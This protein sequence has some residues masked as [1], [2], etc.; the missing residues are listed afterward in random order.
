MPSQK[1]VGIA[2]QLRTLVKGPA[3]FIGLDVGSHSVKAVWLSAGEKTCKLRGW[4]HKI[5]DVKPDAAPE[6]KKYAAIAAVKD[7]FSAAGLEKKEVALSVSGNSVIVR[8]VSFPR[9]S[10]AEMENVLATEAEP[11]IP[12]DIKEVNLA[13]HILRDVL[14][15]GQK[16]METI[17]VAAK[18][19]LIREK[20]EVITGAGLTPL[21]VDV[22]IFALEQ[23]HERLGPSKPGPATLFLNIG[24]KTTNIAIIENGVTRVA[25]DVFIAG[26]MLTKAIAKTI[27]V[28]IPKAEELKRKHG[29]S[30]TQNATES[31][32][33]SSEEGEANQVSAA[34]LEVLKDLMGEIRRS[35]EFYYSQGPDRSIARAMLSGGTASLKNLPLYLSAELKVPVEPVN[36][37]AILTD[38]AAAKIPQELIPSLAVATG[39]ALRKM[40]DWEKK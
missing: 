24:H 12:F 15:D 10:R 36:P 18:K 13:C 23:L 27:Q 31:I 22:D 16:K 14:E 40:W 9:M 38:P 39:L 28:D 29:L 6:E 3:D 4:G 26:N 19:D 5:I 30:L 8:Y 32:R 35:V 37:M 21:L 11:F 2:E 34:I 7:L 20:M 1:N 17:L 33:I 25:R